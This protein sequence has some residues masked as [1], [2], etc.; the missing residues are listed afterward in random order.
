MVSGMRWDH[1]IPI[2][3]SPTQTGSLSVQGAGGGMS[4]LVERLCLA[5]VDVSTTPPGQEPMPVVA[6]YQ[7]LWKRCAY[8]VV[9]VQRG[10]D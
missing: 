8:E 4:I 6:V 5:A 7:L 1:V 2:P 3:Y 10:S 9:E